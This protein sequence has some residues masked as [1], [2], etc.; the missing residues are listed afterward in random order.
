MVAC[1]I[2]NRRVETADAVDRGHCVGQVD[3][4]RRHPPNRP[5]TRTSRRLDCTSRGP[6]SLPGTARE[7]SAP[8]Y[9]GSHLHVRLVRLHSPRFEQ[10]FGQPT[11]LQSVPL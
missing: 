2:I 10:S 4:R 7:Q 1:R 3:A 8:V 11:R 6:S 5:R 9:S